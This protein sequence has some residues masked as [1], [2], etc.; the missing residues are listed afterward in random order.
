ML[1]KI[2]RIATHFGDLCHIALCKE[3][4]L[5]QQ[6]RKHLKH[7][8]RVNKSYLLNLNHACLSVPAPST[9]TLKDLV[10]PHRFSQCYLGC[11]I[12]D[13]PSGM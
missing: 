5:V 11:W 4:I 1:F 12:L 13:V 2:A 10:V 7:I 6:P 8:Y 3:A 9:N